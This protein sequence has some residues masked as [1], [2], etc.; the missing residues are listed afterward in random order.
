MCKAKSIMN[1]Q[2]TNYNNTYCF[3]DILPENFLSQYFS[4]NPKWGF[5]GLGYIVFKRTYARRITDSLTEEWWQTVARCVNG[6][7]KIGAKYTKEEAQRIFDLV[8]NLKCNFAGRMLWQ[9]G[10]STVDRFGLASLLNCWYCSMREPDDFCFVFEHLMLGGGVGFSVRRED[11]HELPRV[12]KGV[13]IT[14][15]STK[16]ADFIVPDSRQGWVELL[17]KVLDSFFNTG[18]SFSYSSILIRGSGE[19]IRGFGGTASGPQILIQGINSI[20]D[21]FKKREGKKLRSIDVLDINNII[22]DIVVAGNV[23][24]SAQIAIGDPDDYLYLR[25]KNWSN[26]NIPNWRSKSNNSINA[27]TYKHISEEIWENGYIIDPKTGM[28]RGEPYGF[29]NMR[30]SQKFGRL[31]EERKDNAEGYNPCAEI[32]LSDGE[33]CNLSELYLNNISSKE[34][35]FECAKLLYK[36]QKAVWNLPAI[37]EKTEKI[38]KKNRRI[39]L[40][41]TGICQSTEEKLKWLDECYTMLRKF[42]SEW[43]SELGVPESIKLTTVKPS[44]CSKKETML[45][46]SNGI[47]SLEE[48]GNING[49][50]WQD[51]EISVA[52]ENTQELSDKFYVNGRVKTYKFLTSGGIELE[53]SESHRY[54]VL[55]KGKYEWVYAPEIQIGDKLPFK[56][57]GYENFGK[58]IEFESFEQKKTTNS[59][60]IIQPKTLS[61]DLSW[62][63]GL[64]LANGSTHD[65]GIRI[66]GDANKQ[67]I[68]EKA[69]KIAQEQFGIVGTIYTRT[70]GDNADLYIN[71]QNLLRWLS[72]NNLIK[73]ATK[74]IEIPKII[75]QSKKDILLSYIDGYAAGDGSIKT[76]GRSFCTISKRMAEQLIVVLRACG[77]NAKCRMMPPTESSLGNNMRYWIS[78]RKGRQ[79]ESRYISKERKEI[80]QIL[81]SLGLEEFDYDEIVDISYG[82][83]ETFDISVPNGH[84]YIAESYINHNTLSLLGGATAGVHPAYSEYF[85]RR[86]RIATSDPLVKICRDAGY[87]TE[88]VQRF[89]GSEDYSTTVVEFPC[90]AGENAI[91]AKDVSAIDQMELHKK[92]QTIWSDNSVSVTVY[93]RPEELESIKNWMKENYEKSVKTISF[94]LH[95]EHG[96]KQAPLEEI[97]EQTYRKLI[98]KV[99]PID[100]IFDVGSETLEGIECESGACP[101]K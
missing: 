46:T 100:S 19:P 78:E 64:Y 37:Y 21:V 80:W 63:L 48:I 72:L 27:D 94:L 8:F 5:N 93:Y 34:E 54:R 36:T 1:D 35:L 47:L 55:R 60:L 51:I 90:Y 98:K 92:L 49:E 99:K 75:R 74:D 81:D 7:Q 96:F 59:T 58:E 71:S 101:L 41:V 52:Q 79:A 28:A 44:G 39:G 53:C 70:K 76:H 33:A 11:I 30:L 18:K 32:S 57:G 31:G 24:R 83:N 14:H 82:E 16:D 20:V 69:L 42:D 50:Q 26:G 12:R 77:I 85:I 13:D 84:T 22:G 45:I 3:S 9:L 4:K 17:R 65:K 43:S 29:I 38:V 91:L 67:D 62:F 56:V 6:A 95:S 89:D 2:I 73:Q 23:R 40:G 86:V 25:A 97:D 10:T 68:L 61:N 87:K 66:A 15:E 88:Y